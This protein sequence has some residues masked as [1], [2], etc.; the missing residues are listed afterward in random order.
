[1]AKSSDTAQQLNVL[2]RAA[3]SGGETRPPVVFVHGAWHGAWSWAT[4]FLDYFADQGFE[5][6][7]PDLRGHGDSP[8]VR[9]MRW[10]RIS[11][12]IDDVLSVVDAL[13]RKPVLIGHSMGGFVAQ[14]CMNRS[15]NL[16]AVGLLGTMPHYGA[17]PVTLNIVRHRPLD[18]IK[19]NLSA[20]L[21][22]LVSNPT[23]AWHMLME[24]EGTPDQIA[25]L[26][27]KL[28]DESYLGFLDMLVL[29]LP[30]KPKA[31]LPVQVV[32]G[33]LDQLF[34]VA[35]QQAVARRYGAKCHVVTG[36]PHNMMLS[37]QWQEVAD[38]YIGWIGQLPGL[39]RRA[40]S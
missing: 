10:N 18:F 1:M 32:A 15:D 34:S 7:A 6:Y 17:L 8:A 14:H 29:N 37:S 4:H 11:H 24:G 23:K 19:L 5:V 25:E 28:G 9:S 31:D 39:K 3:K 35:S 16:A 40:I 22:P 27:A 21:Y 36:A 38:R 20:S 33:E 12:Y 30:K 13:D 26:D 2:H